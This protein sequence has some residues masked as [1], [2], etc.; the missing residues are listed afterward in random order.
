M[1]KKYHYQQSFFRLHADTIAIVGVNLAVA[2]L[3]ISMIISNSHRIDS[4][5][6]RCDLLHSEFINLLKD[7]NK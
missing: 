6:A 3:L 1:S 2:G 4:A 7:G 5:N